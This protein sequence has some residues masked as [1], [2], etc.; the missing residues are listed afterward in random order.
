MFVADFE[1]KDAYIEGAKAAHNGLGLNTNP[2]NEGTKHV[3]WQIGYRAV[4]A[5]SP[6]RL[7]P[8]RYAAPQVDTVRQ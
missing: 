7:F 1:L 6:Q 2:F 3:T 8:A 4:I 5:D